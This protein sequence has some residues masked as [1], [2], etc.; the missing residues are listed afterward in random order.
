MTTPSTRTA[1]MPRPGISAVT[2][3]ARQT[4]GAI[5]LDIGDLAFPTPRDNVAAIKRAAAA[6]RSR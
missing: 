1:G 5:R 6:G 2:D 3:T 4:D